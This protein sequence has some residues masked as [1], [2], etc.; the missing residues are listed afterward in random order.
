MRRSS[1]ALK[2]ICTQVT[3]AGAALVL[4]TRLHIPNCHAVGSVLDE[5]ALLA[6]VDST[7]LVALSPAKSTSASELRDRQCY[8]PI[9]QMASSCDAVHALLR[10]MADGEPRPVCTVPLDRRVTIC[11]WLI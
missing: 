7:D 8:Q 9:V 3:V 1:S 10:S 11:R 2:T 5:H 6:F 4:L